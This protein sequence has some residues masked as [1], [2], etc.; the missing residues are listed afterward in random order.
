MKLTAIIVSV[1][2]LWSANSLAQET[3]ILLGVDG[4]ACPFCAFGIEKQLKKI[5]GVND[6]A[7]DL[8]QGEIWVEVSGNDVL[9][10]DEARTL[11]QDAGF[12]L[13][14]FETHQG[15]KGDHDVHEPGKE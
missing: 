11:L 4:L 5:D 14:S 12:T 2:L 7:I 8:P 6:V 3:H 13:R 15:K 10:E 1:L 9:S